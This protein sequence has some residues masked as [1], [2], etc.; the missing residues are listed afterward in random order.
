MA[1]SQAGPSGVGLAA[2]R[3]ITVHA[4]TAALHFTP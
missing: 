3:E 2:Q 4:V 1:G